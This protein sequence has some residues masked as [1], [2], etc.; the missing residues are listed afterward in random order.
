MS[1]IDHKISMEIEGRGLDVDKLS[2]AFLLDT[3]R[4]FLNQF[5]MQSQCNIK[6]NIH[7]ILL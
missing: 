2:E 7:N 5:S 3:Q 4:N 1:E 6:R